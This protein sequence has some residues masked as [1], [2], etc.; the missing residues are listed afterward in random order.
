M[1]YDHHVAFSPRQTSDHQAANKAA[2]RREQY[3]SITR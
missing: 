1:N 2:M 3:Y